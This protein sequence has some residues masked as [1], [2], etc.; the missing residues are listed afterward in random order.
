MSVNESERFQSATEAEQETVVGMEAEGE[1]QNSGEYFTPSTESNAPSSV[2]EQQIGENELELELFLNEL[3]DNEFETM[4]YELLQ[5]LEGNFEAYAHQHGLTGEM[6][7]MSTNPNFE[8]VI[9]SYSEASVVQIIPKAEAELDSFA[10]YFQA[11]VPVGAEYEAFKQVVDSYQ[12][13]HPEAF[14]KRLAR[15]VAKGVK[16]LA[17]RG[18]SLAKKAVKGIAKVGKALISGPLKA[19]I[20]RLISWIRGAIG[21]VLKLVVRKAVRKLPKAAQP[22]VLRALRKRGLAEYQIPGS[23]SEVSLDEAVTELE[24]YSPE[25]EEMADKMGYELES[26]GYNAE[27]EQ[28]EEL[29]ELHS[30]QNQVAELFAEFDAELF[31]QAESELQQAVQEAYTPEVQAQEVQAYNP[32]VQAYNPEV[33]AYNPEVQAYNPEVQAYTP[34][35]YTPEVQ[36]QEV[37]AYNPEVQAYTPEVQ[38]Q[39]VQA[40]NPE[41]Q[42]PEAFAPESFEQRFSQEAELETI[43]GSESIAINE[44]YENFVNALA[45]NPSS[46]R[47]QFEQFAPIVLIK[48]AKIAFKI[49]PSLRRKVVNLVAQLI[50]KLIGRWIPKDIGN[51][52]YRPLASMLLKLMGLEA[53]NPVLQDRVYAEAIANTATEA[54][55]N[56]SNLPEA[57]LHG[58]MEVLESE[59]EQIVQNAVLNNIPSE[60]L[61]EAMIPRLSRRRIQ[62]L[63]KGKHQSLSRPVRITLNRV[64]ISQTRI[65]G[66]LS[67]GDFF[68]QYYNWDGTSDV[69]LDFAVFRHLP[70]RG[71]ISKILRTY[72]G[73]GGPIQLRARHY[74][75]LHRMTRRTARIFGIPSLWSRMLPTYFIISRVTPKIGSGGVQPVESSEVGKAPARGNDVSAKVDSLGRYRLSIYLNNHT[76]RS[77]RKEGTEAIREVRATL[78]NIISSARAP[79]MRL[80]T[81]IKIPRIIARAITRLLLRLAMSHLTRALS[82]IVQ[83]MKT[84]TN[85]SKGL[86]ISLIVRLPSNF[87]RSLT[88]ISPLR[89]PSLLRTL[90]KAS[91]SVAVSAGYNL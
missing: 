29:E 3:R 91:F 13:I 44:A 32:E 56:A 22:I 33:Q 25:F 19:A 40:Y 73:R 61:N 8:N 45:A 34:E 87:P 57:V 75:Q 7:Q 5:E 15:R 27:L 77:L 23:E 43:A 10:N 2:Y 79:L 67:L 31:N 63:P 76:V 24:S 84:L 59:L 49:I 26:E 16:G 12:P 86:T 36:A 66:N 37:Q 54:L 50:E 81:R 53:S 82:R 74:R 20:R 28:E 47:P 71:S 48:G 42:T 68:R 41:V 85:T 69:M 88:G 62:F 60:A 72:F 90:V 52:V 30:P 38:A 11:N 64:Q 39:E 89:I 80:L 17:K 58:D 35:A 6:E 18:L 46:F 83:R 55:L 9:N 78:G 21:R 51:V 1:Y 14:I 65:R 4:T 70:G